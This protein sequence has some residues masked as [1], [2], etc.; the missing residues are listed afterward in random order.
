M[1]PSVLVNK[2][3]CGEISKWGREKELMKGIRQQISQFNQI[4]SV[5]MLCLDYTAPA[6]LADDEHV[7]ALSRDPLKKHLVRS[8]I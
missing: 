7:T 8:L 1:D 4:Q 6:K 2:F 5:K 3:L